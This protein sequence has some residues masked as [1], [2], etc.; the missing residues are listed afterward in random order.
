ML[1]TVRD[2]GRVAGTVRQEDAVGL[3]SQDLGGR[4][5]GGHD[6]DGGELAELGEDRALDAEV[7]GDDPTRSRADRVGRG[8]R[9]HGDEVDAVGAGLGGCRGRHRSLVGRAERAR[10]GPGVADVAG[11]PA[12]VDAGDAREPVRAQEGVEV[13]VAA[14]VAPPPGEVADDDAPAVRG[15]G[16][17]VGRHRAVVA[18]VGVGERD[19]LSGVGRVGDDL[20]VAAEG[21]VEHDLAA[22]HAAR[23]L[24]TDGLALEHRAVGQDEDCFADAHR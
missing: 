16:L 8:A 5:G 4:G 1:S 7:V 11:E 6:L 15:D 22:R 23:G 3:A 21:R 24:G 12:R 18:D 2:R 20:L 13:A 14:P 17:V 9:D 10:H 19:D